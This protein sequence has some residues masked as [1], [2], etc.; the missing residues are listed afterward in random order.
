MYSL[1]MIDPYGDLNLCYN[2]LVKRGVARVVV[3]LFLLDY[4]L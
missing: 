4:T 3:L 2:R 1:A